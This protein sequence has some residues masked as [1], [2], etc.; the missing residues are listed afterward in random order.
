MKTQGEK[1]NE[2]QTCLEAVGPDG[3][4]VL[5]GVAHGG[6]AGK[7]GDDD[8]VA[9]GPEQLQY[10]LKAN[11][12]AAARDQRHAARQI[13]ALQPLAVVKVPAGAAHAGVEGVHRRK[14]CPAAVAGLSAVQQRPRAPLLLLLHPLLSRTAVLQQP[15]GPLARRPRVKGHRHAAALLRLPQPRGRKQHA[16]GRLFL[17]AIGLA[18]G[19]GELLAL[20]GGGPHHGPTR[21]EQLHTV[22]IRQ[23]LQHRPVRRHL[24]QKPHR[25]RVP[26]LQRLRLVCHPRARERKFR[27][28]PLT[29]KKTL[30]SSVTQ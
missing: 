7:A 26:L 16:I 24:A 25:S 13:A 23:P 5:L 12:D 30:T 20:L 22:L 1:R 27:Q 6:V 17:C 3:K 10:N 2:Q 8:D 18:K 29:K 14:A 9:A 19:D 15:R 11:L 28:P 4:V 21:L